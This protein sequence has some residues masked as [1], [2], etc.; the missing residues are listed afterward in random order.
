M[1]V[2]ILPSS[3]TYVYAHRVFSAFASLFRASRDVIFLSY[4]GAS[5]VRCVHV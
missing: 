3:I 4:F 2:P 1:L 5:A